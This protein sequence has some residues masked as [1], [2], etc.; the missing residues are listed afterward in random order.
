[1]HIIIQE[2]YTYNYM[3]TQ[4][5]FVA[6]KIL[7]ESFQRFAAPQQMKNRIIPKRSLIEISNLD[8]N[9]SKCALYLSPSSRLSQA[10][11]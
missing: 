10:E 7:L 6:E 3:T 2:K 1:M 5:S 8:H 9:T 11:G 4:T